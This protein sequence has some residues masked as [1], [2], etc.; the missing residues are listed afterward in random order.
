MTH[1]TPVA[2]LIGGVLIGL[3]AG[4]LLVV[5]G[6]IAG[7]SGMLGGLLQPRPG[8][9]A[10]RA[11]FLAGLAGGGVLLALAWPA[12]FGGV[13][14]DRA[15]PIVAVAGLLVG[16]G[17]RMANG[18]TSGHGVC[19]ISRMAP[20]SIVATVTFMVA[21]MVTVLLVRLLGGAS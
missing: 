14:A 2:S 3:A 7:V 8:D 5:H 21:G 9:V 10:W 12:A 18:C 11:W 6:K 13:P 20:R 19:G 15:L 4:L 16:F 1:F 17:T